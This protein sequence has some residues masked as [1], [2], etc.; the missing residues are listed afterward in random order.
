MVVTF[1]ALL[2][3]GRKEGRKDPFTHSPTNC[4]SCPCIVPS[5]YHILDKTHTCTHNKGC[6]GHCSGNGSTGNNTS[7]GTCSSS[8]KT[9]RALQELHDDKKHAAPLSPRR[10]RT[11]S[12]VLLLFCV[13]LVLL[14]QF[15]LNMVC[16]KQP[17]NAKLIE[18]YIHG[19]GKSNTYMS[20]YV[21]NSNRLPVCRWI[22]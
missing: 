8:D 19:R 4:L 16:P 1:L 10:R 13:V 14:G 12:W 9:A 5:M 7:P 15:H 17:D 18:Y 2:K 3:E 22:H 11:P 20:A 21:C 6:E